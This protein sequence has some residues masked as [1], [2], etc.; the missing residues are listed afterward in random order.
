MKKKGVSKVSSSEKPWII[1]LECPFCNETILEACDCYDQPEDIEDD[2]W[3]EIVEESYTAENVVGSCEHLAYLG[4]WG[5]EEMTEINTDWSK[6]LNLIA[7][8]LSDDDEFDEDES[9]KNLSE[10][11][12]KYESNNAY[13]ESKLIDKLDDIIACGVLTEDTDLEKSIQEV[14]GNDI[15]IALDSIYVEAGQGEHGGGPTFATLFMKRK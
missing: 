10:N 15:E 1:T 6:E 5:Y 8:N 2:E 9:N 4:A 13:D 7:R 3:E 11:N 14:V 12:V